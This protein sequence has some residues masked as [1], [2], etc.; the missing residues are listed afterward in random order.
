MF[1][2][3]LDSP[4]SEFSFIIMIAKCFSIYL[5]PHPW[6]NDLPSISPEV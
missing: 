3:T 1:L 4:D 5:S 6:R 2:D